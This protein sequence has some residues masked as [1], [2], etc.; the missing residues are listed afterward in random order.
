MPMHHRGFTII[1]L[2][3]VLAIIALLLTIAAPRY[4]GSISR[5]QDD[6]LKENLHLLRDAIDRH[7]ADRGRYPDSLEQLVERRYLRAIP[8]DPV[9]DSASSWITIP[10]PDKASGNVFDVKSGARGTGRNGVPYAHW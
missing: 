7:Y 3:V 8:P 10:P 9:T 5:A 6:V 2:L 4:W 1:E